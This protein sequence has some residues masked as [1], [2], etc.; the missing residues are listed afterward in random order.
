MKVHGFKRRASHRKGPRAWDTKIG[1]R[2]RDE[3]H[4]NKRGVVGKQRLKEGERRDGR[5]FTR[6]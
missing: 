2:I 1:R 4:E 6:R 5:R 3:S